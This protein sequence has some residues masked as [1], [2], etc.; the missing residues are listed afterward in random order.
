[1]GKCATNRQ[2]NTRQNQNYGKSENSK[3][4]VWNGETNALAPGPAVAVAIAVVVPAVDVAV[5]GDVG[6]GDAPAAAGVAETGA[7]G[8]RDRPAD[9]EKRVGDNMSTLSTTPRPRWTRRRT[10]AVG[11]TLERIMAIR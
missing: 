10:T 5:D 9:E 7:S 4:P 3:L 11:C 1:M 8:D 6:Y 2:H